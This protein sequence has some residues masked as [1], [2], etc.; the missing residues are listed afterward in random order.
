MLN[1][2]IKNKGQTVEV[3]ACDKC[4]CTW[5]TK[6]KVNRYSTLQQP[7]SME[8]QNVHFEADFNLLLCAA[9]GTVV[10]PP[11]ESLQLAS[12]VHQLYNEMAEEV[13]GSKEA[14]KEKLVGTQV[15]KYARGVWQH[16]VKKPPKDDLYQGQKKED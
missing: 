6:L 4:K 14:A 16:V 11:V 15:D 10:F 8:P 3:V 1:L 9:C 12:A 13:T 7:L 5:L 2:P